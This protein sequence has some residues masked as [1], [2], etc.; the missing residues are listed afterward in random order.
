MCGDTGE[1]IHSSLAN[2]VFS[3]LK[4]QLYPENIMPRTS[5]LNEESSFIFCVVPYALWV[6]GHSVMLQ[7]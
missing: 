5:E 3:A 6:F 2:V 1:R 7:P 4:I